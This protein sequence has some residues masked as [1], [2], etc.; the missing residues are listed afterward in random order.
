MR[1][2]LACLIGVV[3]SC[4]ATLAGSASAAALRI[5][6]RVA[7]YWLTANDS[8]FSALAYERKASCRYN[9]AHTSLTCRLTTSGVLEYTGILTRPSRCAYR[10]TIKTPDGFVAE[11]QTLHTCG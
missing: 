3:L 4:S 6:P 10:S 7:H 2:G 1:F 9:R 11:R 8:D 5:Q